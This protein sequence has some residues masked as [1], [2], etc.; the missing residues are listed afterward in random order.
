MISQLDGDD[1]DASV[2]LFS[3]TAPLLLVGGMSSVSLREAIS[4]AVL[5]TLTRHNSGP[6]AA[7]FSRNGSIVATAGSD[8]LVH[9]SNASNGGLV[10]SVQMTRSDDNIGPILALSADG[11]LLA[12]AEQSE[13]PVIEI[14]QVERGRRLRTVAAQNGPIVALLF[15]ENDQLLSV[16]DDGVVH[17]YHRAIP[18]ITIESSQ[19]WSIAISPDSE[20]YA[21]FSEEGVVNVRST[22]DDALRYAVD[23]GERDDCLEYQP[24]GRGF[25]VAAAGRLQFRAAGTGALQR[26]VRAH[27]EGIADCAFSEDGS[28]LATGSYGDVVKVWSVADGRLVATLRGHQSTVQAVAFSPDGSRLFSGGGFFLEGDDDYSIRV[29]R[30]SDWSLERTFVDHT[31]MVQD[32]A[33]SHDGSLVASAGDDGV[34]IWRPDTGSLVTRIAEGALCVKFSR[35]AARLAICSMNR[36]SIWHVPSGRGVASLSGF[37][38]DTANA[39]DAEFSRDERTI[40]TTAGDN[41]VRRWAIPELVASLDDLL[42]G[43]CRLLAERSRRFTVEEIARD[44]LLLSAWLDRNAP[45][46]ATGVETPANARPE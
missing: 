45:V 36:V 33:V 43:S 30:V 14:W 27:D 46:C 20:T 25:V 12:T 16:G 8:G 37:N 31:A 39:F 40:F 24:D 5:A 42:E 1:G 26:E 38:S 15:D 21:L 3:P 18:S 19:F 17:R 11:A 44:P 10:Q 6:V 29:W 34:R 4:G 2:V 28:L 7:A 41:T 35:D 13:G 32:I 9:I 22:R 23:L